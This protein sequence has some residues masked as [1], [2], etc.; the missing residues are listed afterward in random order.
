[1]SIRDDLELEYPSPPRR[2]W[3]KRFLW[4]GLS[5]LLVLM[6]G[7]IVRF[8]WNEHAAQNEL[9]A[10]IAELD[11]IDPQWRLEDIEV[12]RKVILDE[13]NAA[14]V[15]M[16]IAERMPRHWPSRSAEAIPS[17]HQSQLLDEKLFEVGPE[18]QL[19]PALTHELRA[20]LREIDPLPL[21]A[22]SLAKLQAGRFPIAW[23]K[24][25]LSTPIQCQDARLVANLLR[26]DAIL[27][28]QEGDIE[29]ALISS[30]GILGSARSIG[31]EPVIVSQLI[32][33]AIDVVAVLSLERTLAQGQAS[34]DSLATCQN[35]LQEEE[36]TPRLLIAA[37]G[38]RAGCNRL[39]GS[40]ESEE[41][42]LSQISDFAGRPLGRFE[43]AWRNFAVSPTIKRSHTA[44]L[45]GSTEYIEIARL[46]LEEQGERFKEF[47]MSVRR[48]ELLPLARLVLPGMT[49]HAA[50]EQR[51]RA[52]LRV[53]VA[54]LAAERFRLASK[55]WPKDLGD[56][57]PGYL[58]NVPTDPYDGQQLRLRVLEDG[59]AIYSIG[60]DLQDNGGAIS[61][62]NPV[63]PGS[64]LGFRLWNIEAR[65]RPAL[66][67]DVGPPQPT[68]EDLEMMELERMQQESQNA[69]PEKL[70]AP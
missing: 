70:K 16:D 34:G 40:L 63:V 20:K 43:A 33:M 51:A 24:D 14:L 54:A 6:I 64:D 60:P 65:R 52:N 23:S 66:N 69:P 35:R 39:M 25:F 38:N 1:M 50:A 59:I 8:K 62:Q 15:V 53:A 5:L 21:N 44:I 22:R 27:R 4:S 46:P 12:G 56:L 61:R 55:R 37:R 17:G 30:E 45:R 48:E 10:V 29:G 3:W 49:K 26:F 57:V 31:D 47:E 67:P 32:R 68:P 18:Q 13:E 19:D 36:E 9:S 2:R 58:D 41:V 7:G 42:K 11:A 28:A